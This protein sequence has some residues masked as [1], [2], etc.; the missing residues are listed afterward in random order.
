MIPAG[1]KGAFPRV[2]GQGFGIPATSR[3]G[4]PGSHRMGIVEADARPPRQGAWRPR[5]CRRSV[6]ESAAYREAF[7]VNGQDLAPLYLKTLERA[8]SGY[9]KYRRI[10]V[11]SQVGGAINR[12]IDASPPNSSMLRR[13]CDTHRRRQS[14]LSTRQASRSTAERQKRRAYQGRNALDRARRQRAKGSFALT[15]C[16]AAELAAGVST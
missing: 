11:C 2:A 7:T 10:S 8:D 5:P 16:G 14:R 12:A 15:L 6:V 9:M 13:R 1:P 3:R 4:R